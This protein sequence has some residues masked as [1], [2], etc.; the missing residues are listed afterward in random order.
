MF[1][2]SSTDWWENGCG[3]PELQKVASLLLSICPHACG[4]ERTWSVFGGVLSKSRTLL[5]IGRVGLLA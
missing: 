1:S 2:I 4:C 3:R 5:L